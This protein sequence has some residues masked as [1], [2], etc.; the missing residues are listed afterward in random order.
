VVRRR[1]TGALIVCGL[2][3]GAGVPA[4]A[5]GL[6][7]R[8]R[9]IWTRPD[10]TRV[11]FRP[12]VRVWCGRWASD[13]PVPSIHVW[14]GVSRARHWELHA[15][16][17]DVKRRPVVRLPNAFVFDHPK[18]ALLFATD[19]GNELNSDTDDSSGSI[20]FQR[21]SC[22]RRLRIAFRFTGRV[23]SELSDGEPLSVRGSFSA[24]T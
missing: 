9:L 13:V 19:R 6:R 8:D 23:A 7:V 4:H 24:S 20:R 10:G 22:G 17:A 11:A 5:A 12:D 21:V 15:V 14:V 18:G 3:A 16:V 1:I 2:A